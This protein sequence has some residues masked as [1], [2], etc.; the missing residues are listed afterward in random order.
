MF[1]YRANASLKAIW[2]NEDCQQSVIP[3]QVSAIKSQLP[4][5][6]FWFQ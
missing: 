6:N 3:E 4:A 2:S 1:F 5:A